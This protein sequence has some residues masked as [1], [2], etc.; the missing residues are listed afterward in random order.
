VPRETI[1]DVNAR[2]A[3]LR[4]SAGVDVPPRELRAWFL[5]LKDHPERYESST[6]GGFVFTE[7]SYG[8]EGAQFETHERLA[9]IRVRLR[10]ELTVV[11]NER[12]AFRLLAPPLAVW[13]A[14]EIEPTEGGSSKVSVLIGGGSRCAEWFLRLP[15]VRGAVQQQIQ[16]EVEHIRSSVA[17]LRTQA[18]RCTQE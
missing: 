7:G 1:R 12:F 11:E 15:P 17:R 13:G 8:V 5:A 2:Y 16:R 18:E 9:G 4:A 6:H 3:V 14:F 10:F